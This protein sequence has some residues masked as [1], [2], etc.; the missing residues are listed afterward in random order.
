MKINISVALAL[1]LSAPQLHAGEI[2]SRFLCTDG[3]IIRLETNT[4][5]RMVVT[6]QGNRFPVRE[7]S[8]ESYGVHITGGVENQSTVMMDIFWLNEGNRKF[9]ATFSTSPKADTISVECS[10]DLGSNRLQF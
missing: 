9:F 8:P 5:P 2:A 10:H 1:L 6:W 4:G 7:I 3:S